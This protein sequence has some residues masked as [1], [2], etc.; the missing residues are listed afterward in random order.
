MIWMGFP[1]YFILIRVCGVNHTKYM[2]NIIRKGKQVF[3]RAKQELAI[4]KQGLA[5]AKQELAIWRQELAIA[6]QKLA[7][8]KQEFAHGMANKC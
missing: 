3:M 2:A 7:I 6:K 8:A 5:I 1:D 4:W